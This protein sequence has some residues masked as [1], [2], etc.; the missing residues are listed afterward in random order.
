MYEFGVGALFAKNS[1]G[2][3]VEFGILQ[4][5]SLDFSFDKKELYGRRQFPVHVARGKGKIEGKATY[6]NIQAAAL[7][8]VLNGTISTGELIVAEPVTTSV[9]ATTPYTI[10]I[11][12]PASGTMGSILAV[13]DVSGATKVPMQLVTGTPT[14]GQYSYATGTLTFA[15]ADEGKAIQYQYD[16]KVTTGK[17]LQ[18]TNSMMGTAPTFEVELYQTLDNIPL[19]VVLYKV[20]TEKLTMNM[21]NEDYMIPDFSFS[22][23]ANAADTVGNIYLG[24]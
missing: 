3:S 20:T 18:M 12:P 16:Y 11:T 10:T 9:P 13:Y 8:A 19:T 6:A 23:F 21:K 5:V 2:S 14:T 1:D 22:A 4:D 7:N 17:T 24:E 15:A